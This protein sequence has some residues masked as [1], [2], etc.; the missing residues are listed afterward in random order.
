METH[1]LAL[2]AGYQLEQFRIEAVL[3]KQ[4]AIKGL[5]PVDQALDAPTPSPA[6]RG[7]TK[8]SASNMNPRL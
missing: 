2:A 3:G 5:M 4:F 7:C 1:R 6:R 8:P